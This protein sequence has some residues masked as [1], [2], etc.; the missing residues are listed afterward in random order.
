M[1]TSAKTGLKAQ[2]V[3]IRAAKELYLF[4]LQ[5]KDRAPINGSITPIRTPYKSGMNINN[6]YALKDEVDTV[7]KRKKSANFKLLFLS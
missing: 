6:N 4:H 7:R 5:Y 3:F 2:D 1:E